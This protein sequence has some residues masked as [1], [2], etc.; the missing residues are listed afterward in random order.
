M[1]VIPRVRADRQAGKSSGRAENM[2]RK[3]TKD[4]IVPQKPAV[5]GNAGPRVNHEARGNAG[6]RK[7][8]VV[9]G[10]WLLAALCA[11][12]AGAA[13]CCWLALCLLFWQGSWQLLYHPAAAVTRTPAS[14]ELA[15]DRVEFAATDVGV[16]RL[17]GW[18]IPAAPGAARA[19][20]TVIYLHGQYGNIGDTVAALARLHAAGVNVLA[21]DYRGYGDSQQARPSE[22]NWLQDAEWGVNYLTGTRHIDAD[23]I[24]LDGTGLGAN[25]ALEVGAEHPELA[26]VVVDSPVQDPAGAIFNDARARMVPARLLMRDRYD[27]DAAATGLRVP[28]LWFERT[29]ASSS[30]QNP[31][32]YE[33]APA[34]KMIVWLNPASDMFKQTEEALGR[35]LDGLTAR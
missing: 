28:L 7:P 15:F 31:E 20:F 35:W 8:P 17:K 30:T 29:N 18:W 12:I 24:V 21:F 34:R 13:I 5:S 19:R 1:E 22:R 25:L 14:A 32:G 9:S 2:S 23:S 27:L 10:R 6:R 4:Q 3:K 11:T 33:R 16:P 26:G